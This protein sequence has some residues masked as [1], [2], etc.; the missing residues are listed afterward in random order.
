[1]KK[2][3]RFAVLVLVVLGVAAG[4]GLWKV[5]QLADSKITVKE[6]TIFT[7]KQGTG[8]IAL[9]KQL[10]D[11]KIITR[12]RVFQWL[13]RAEPELANFKAGTYRLTPEMTVRDALRL[14]ASG[15]EAQFPLRLVEGM[16]LSDWLKQLHDAPHIKHTLPD[17]NYETVA[18][19]VGID[20]PQWVE[21][22]FWP[23][24]WSYTA[25][26]TDVTIL[27]RAHAR[28]VKA[29]D[30]AWEG[31]APGLPY[32]DKNQLV[33]MASIIE[34]ETAVASERDRVA[35]VFINRLRIGMRLQTDPTVIY[36]M[37]EAY[38]GNITRKDLETPTPYN[39]YVI[40][41]LPPGPIA[42]PGQASLTAAAHPAKTSYL[43]FVA[44]GKGGHA[45]TT[46]LSSHNQ[47]VQAYLKS[48]KGKNEK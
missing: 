2:M 45:F 13:L 28:M 12:P 7:L 42:M 31:R 15:K 26:T 29:V 25:H 1:M 27:K 41:G 16:R 11:E 23:D 9:G 40:S 5:R 4:A 46:N 21:G 33:T 19:A 32:K 3:L 8:R 10:Y 36:G 34:K 44:D 22:W 43:Y 6:E 48:L 38:N 37:G 39:T 24:T 14:L 18:K 30:E 17:A 47:A 20:N 35:S